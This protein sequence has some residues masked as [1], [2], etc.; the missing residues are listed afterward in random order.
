MC[1]PTIV[2]IA[3]QTEFLMTSKYVILLDRFIERFSVC[4]GATMWH[5]NFHI[6]CHPLI[7]QRE[8]YEEMRA[9]KVFI[10][11]NIHKPSTHKYIYKYIYIFL[12]SLSFINIWNIKNITMLIW[13]SNGDEMVGLATV[14]SCWLH[15]FLFINNQSLREGGYS[16]FMIERKQGSLT[17]N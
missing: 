13:V 12:F 15:W 10:F 5:T 9:R 6:K 8:E 11:F 2:A 1:K 16:V 14:Q 17:W 3:I 7:V 4:F